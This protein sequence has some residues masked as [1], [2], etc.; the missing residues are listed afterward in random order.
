MK[1]RG[2]AAGLVLMTMVMATGCGSP[3]KTETSASQTT[4][5]T[6]AIDTQSASV[7]SNDTKDGSVVV[8]TTYGPVKGVQEG[9]LLTWYGIP[10]GKARWVN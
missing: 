8:S 10:Y 5:E 9:E 7:S 3:A 4:T 2:L 6:T 1:K